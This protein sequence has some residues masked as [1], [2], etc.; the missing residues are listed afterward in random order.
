MPRV[1]ARV[2]QEPHLTKD[3]IDGYTAGH[4]V[5]ESTSGG[6]RLANWEAFLGSGN[7]WGSRTHQTILDKTRRNDLLWHA[8]YQVN[9][10]YGFFGLTGDWMKP[11]SSWQS[12][13]GKFRCDG[14]VEYFYR[15][16]NR[17]IEHSNTN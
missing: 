1:P 12:G 17:S 3:T 16:V 5:I 2:L 11:N 8:Q 15:Q 10:E 14:L 6:V 7:Y 13:D 9:A 4:W